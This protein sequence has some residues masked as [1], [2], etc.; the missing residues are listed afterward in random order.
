MKYIAERI[1]IDDAICNGK[2]TIRG[3]RIT[4][5]TILEFLSAGEGPKEIL[6]Q[7]P[8]LELEDIT[9]CLKFAAD[10]MNRHYAIQAAESR[11]Q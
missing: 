2:P 7:Y 1:T 3:N 10:L 11:A 8:S 6:K 4:V 5:Q 9:A